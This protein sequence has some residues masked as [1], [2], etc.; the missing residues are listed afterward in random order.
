MEGEDAELPGWGHWALPQVDEQIDIENQP[1]EFMELQDLME[2]LNDNE[3]LAVQQVQEAENNSS[4]T[5][6]LAPTNSSAPTFESANGHMMEPILQNLPDLN[7]IVAQ[8]P[9][10]NIQAAQED[11]YCS[12]T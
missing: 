3:A 1:G 5:L 12:A 8:D 6:S 11:P 9:P 2:P 4:L 7:M 10:P